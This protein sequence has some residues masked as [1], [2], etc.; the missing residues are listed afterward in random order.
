MSWACALYIPR[1]KTAF[2][3]TA[4]RTK[5]R[6]PAP[7]PPPHRAAALPASARPASFR[8]L[9]LLLAGLVLVGAAW[10]LR[11][12]PYLREPILKGKDVAELEAAVRARP[13]DALARY[14]LAKRYYLQRRF[15]EATAAYEA[16]ARLDPDSA[17]I[18]LGLA[19]SLYEM[20]KRQPARAAFEQTLQRNPRSA[21]AEYMLGK[22]LWQEGNVGDAL[23]RVRRATELDPRSDTAWY[24]LGVC[25]AHRHQYSEAIGALQN[26]LARRETSP[27][28]HTALGEMLLYRGKTDEGKAHYERALQLQPDYGPACAL[29]GNFYLRKAAGAGALT[30]A[31]EL[32]NRATRLSTVRPA[33]VWLDL[34]QLY[35]QTAQYPKAVAALQKSLA[36]DTRDE[37][38]YYALANAYR[39]KGDAKNAAAAEARFRRISALHVRMQDLEARLGHD[40]NNVSARRSLT[41]VYRDLGLPE[42][43]ARPPT[44]EFTL[45][46]AR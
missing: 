6:N 35:I 30:R 20:G 28:Y 29:L 22:M 15:P 23:L 24:G 18:R 10:W 14:Y 36:V 43:A 46:P 19:L 12:S 2:M 4:P 37:R 9:P 39:R 5:R 16:A 38:A 26:A 42:P 40:P 3:S 31:E 45:P 13:D 7:P 8:L 32:L 41:R 21:W 27:Q 1:R 34:G 44:Q 11:S 33:D 25:Y 17:R